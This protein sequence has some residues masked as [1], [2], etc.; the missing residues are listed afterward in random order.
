MRPG[1]IEIGTSG[2]SFDDWVG[3]FYPLRVPRNQWLEYYAARFSIGEI[4]STYYRIAAPATYAS[5]AR[6]SPEGFRMFAKVHADV[7]HA[8]REPVQ[9][10]HALR[11]ALRPLE[12]SG[13]LL[14]LLAQFP[15]GFRFSP[16]NLDYVTSLSSDC[17]ALPL[18]VEFRHRGWVSDEVMSALGESGITWVCPDEPG[19]ADLLPF[20]LIASSDLL[21]VRLHGRNAAAWYDRSAG[22]R[23]HYDYSEKELMA[24]GKALLESSASAK[25]AFVLFNNCYA[26]NAPRNA[27]W[28]KTW[29]DG[30]GSP[31]ASQVDNN[32]L[33]LS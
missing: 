21:Y 29:L 27:W 16:A 33:L 5:I 26:G 6:R 12:E 19:L 20:R 14:G 3:P 22:D 11:S 13:K 32:G 10:L 2:W 24:F 9:S 4:N 15:A 1:D 8:R 25:R 18:C 23:Y 17:G 7:T 28:L 30:G 31:A